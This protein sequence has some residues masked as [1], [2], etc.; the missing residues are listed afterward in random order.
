[1]T[2]IYI[3]Y[4]WG[5]KNK[6]P[7]RASKACSVSWTCKEPCSIVIWV[8]WVRQVVRRW[9]KQH[10]KMNSSYRILIEII[11]VYGVVDK[12]ID[13][14]IRTILRWL[15]WAAAKWTNSPPFG[16]IT[17]PLCNKLKAG[18]PSLYDCTKTWFNSQGIPFCRRQETCL[19]FL[20]LLA[21][22]KCHKIISA[23]KQSL[24]V[25]AQFLVS[26]AE[27]RRK[28]WKNCRTNISV[29]SSGYR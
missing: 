15:G 11:D 5:K 27:K 12:K 3:V 10:E 17:D 14:K 16:R 18:D 13:T 25:I 19:W 28:R 9:R 4:F 6:P 1:M 23:V 21:L 29:V 26:P 2:Y 7:D 20:Q 8:F 22:C 24:F